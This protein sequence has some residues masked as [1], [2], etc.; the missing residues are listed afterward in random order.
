MH[1]FGDSKGTIYNI[2]RHTG[3]LNTYRE[4]NINYTVSNRLFLNDLF[5]FWY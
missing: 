1:V 5:I 2:N 3:L 4:H